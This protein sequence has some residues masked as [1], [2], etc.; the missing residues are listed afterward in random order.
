MEMEVD[1]LRRDNLNGLPAR[2]QGTGRPVGP[3]L[4]DWMRASDLP[5]IAR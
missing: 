3:I 5:I 2:H 4:I 1:A